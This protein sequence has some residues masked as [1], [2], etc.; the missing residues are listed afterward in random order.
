MK[1]KLLALSILLF[2]SLRADEYSFTMYNDF[3]AGTDG[4]FTN[5]VSLA[6]LEDNQKNSY[7]NFLTSTFDTLSFPLNGLKNYNA[8]LSIN[9]IMV[10]PNVTTI[11]VPQYNDLPYAGYLSLET[12]LF[13][14]DAHSFNEYSLEI[15]V[16]GKESGAEFMQ[17]TFHKMI[18]NK[19]P[20][21]WN[22]QLG[23]G[24]TVN[25][26]L[27]HGVKQWQ[28]KIGH[29]LQADWFY[30]YG[31]TLG[32]FNLSAFGGTAFRVG[33]NYVH[34][35]NAHYPY[36]KEESGL[37]SVDGLKQGFGW[38]ASGGIDGEYLAYSYIFDKAKDEGYAVDIAG[39][40]AVANLSASLYY[41]HHKFRFFYEIPSH[42]VK[43]EKG[44][45]IFGGFIYSYKF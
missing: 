2:V 43:E 33:Q 6:W 41:N 42:Y 10:T 20:K 1:I 24:Y 44:V 16:I 26:L 7:T 30:H 14:W 35:F 37:I 25:L 22:T 17:K 18:G 31:A 15:G 32:T 39:L 23:T 9:Q 29:N 28:G 45:N 3:F 40:T 19:E 36:L 34:N 8:G 11:A 5:A 12:Y 4:H 13:E 21:G 38:S 27:Q